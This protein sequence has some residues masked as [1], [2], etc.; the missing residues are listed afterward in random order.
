MFDARRPRPTSFRF[1]CR[2]RC[3]GPNTVNSPVRVLTR[4]VV[5][6]D[7]SDEETA[8]DNLRAVAYEQIADAGSKL[9]DWPVEEIA[10]L[11]ARLIRAS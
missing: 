6:V 3:V 1:S 11:D 10:I 8:R 9:L 4:Y 5:E 2:I 7:A